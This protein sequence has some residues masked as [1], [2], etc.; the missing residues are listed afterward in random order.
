MKILQ[1]SDLNKSFGSVSAAKSINFEMN[2]NEIVGIIGSNGAGKTTFCNIIT[3]YTTADNGKVIFK[4]EDITNK[5][6][7][8]IKNK[9]IHRSFQIPQIFENLSVIENIMIAEN[10]AQKKQNVFWNTAYS[11]EVKTKALELLSKF[12]IESYTYFLAKE[13]PQGAR[14]ILDILLAILGDPALIMLDEPTSGI[15]A[16]EK[17]IVM[18]K[19]IQAIKALNISIMFIEH[20]MEIV[21]KFS[22]RIVAFY[23]GEILAEGSPGEVFK[24]EKVKKYIIGN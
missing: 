3:G 13:L 12:D 9:G 18:E 8:Y 19:I 16:D 7:Q 5:D 10:V 6:I 17:D 2:T 1:V 11:K 24:Q 20:D 22:E 21:A 15:S 4:K 14:K 23:D